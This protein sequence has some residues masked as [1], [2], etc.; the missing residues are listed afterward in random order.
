[1]TALIFIDAFGNRKPFTRWNLVDDDV[2]LESEIGTINDWGSKMRWTAIV[3]IVIVLAVVA[4]VLAGNARRNE[5]KA[6][7]AQALRRAVLDKVPE[8]NTAGVDEPVLVVMDMVYPGAVVSV[9]SATT[10][11]ASIYYS[12]GGGVL[13]GIGDENVRTAAKAFVQEVARQRGQFAA[14]TDYAYPTGSNVR[15]FLRTPKGVYMAEAPKESLLNGPSA[16]ATAFLRAQDVITQLRMISGGNETATSAKGNPPPANVA[17]IDALVAGDFAKVAEALKAGADANAVDGRGAAALVIA[18]SQKKAPEVQLL[19]DAGA[20]PN[21]RYTDTAGKLRNAP[22]VQ[23]AAANGSVEMLRLLA[24]AGADLN[25]ADA[26]GLTPL[27]AAAFM[28]HSDVVDALLKAG[29]AREGR[30]EAGYTALMFASNAGKAA[31]VQH[32]LAA[33]ADANARDRDD[34]TPIMFAAQAGFDDCVRLLCAA[35]ADPKA[36]G[37]HGLSAIAFARQ[38]GHRSTERLLSTCR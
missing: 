16:L 29:A 30:D 1:M 8:G 15:F 12:N 26:T 18:V 11:D 19:L 23:F 33:G 32:L 37:R 34:S 10:G 25:A 5:S 24:K 4:L 28:G 21:A 35:G 22:A 20:D 38:N 31:V 2:I 17:L 3:V 27:M 14:V 6:A 36:V 9:M 7:V 13:G